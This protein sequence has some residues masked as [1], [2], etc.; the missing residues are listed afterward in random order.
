MKKMI[1]ATLMLV[2][3]S[4]S[5]QNTPFTNATLETGW[6]SPTT[7]TTFYTL[8]ASSGGCKEIVEA[9]DDLGTMV[10]SDGELAPPRATDALDAYRKFLAEKNVDTTGIGDLELAKI[11]LT[12]LGESK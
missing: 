9:Q 7:S 6:Y 5:A 8:W 10:S 2:S 11:A 3:V 1:L 12:K 4:A